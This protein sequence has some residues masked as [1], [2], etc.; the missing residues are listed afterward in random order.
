MK[1][2]NMHC[3]TSMALFLALLLA[4]AGCESKTQSIVTMQH[5]AAPK[6][7]VSKPAPAPS[8]APAP[9]PPPTPVP[10]AQTVAT[11]IPSPGAKPRSQHDLKVN[12]DDFLAHIAVLADDAMGGRGIGSRGIDQAAA[13]IAGQFALLGIAPGG[14]DGTYFQEFEVSTG[15]RLTDDHKF[16]VTG[17]ESTPERRA[18]F[19]PF[20]FSSNDAFDGEVVFVG[21]GLVNDEKNHDDYKDVDVSGKVVLMLRREPPTWAESGRTTRLATFQNKIYT[22]KEKG[23]AAVLIV[24][25]IAEDREDRLMGFRAQRGAFGLPA[26]HITQ[27]LA[28]QM[29]ASGGARNL[30]ALQSATD[31][32]QPVS[33][34]LAG[35]H[36]AG[37][38]GVEKT[39]TRERNVLGLIP[40]DGPLADEY[41]V[42]GGHYDHLGKAAT[43]GMLRQ[44][45]SDSEPRI[46]NGADD[47]ASG[48]AGVIES[49]RI[50]MS[51]RPLKRS[52][53][54]M[55][56][57]G[58]ETGL[59]G[60]KH[61]ADNPVFP[62][63]NTVAMLNMDMIGRFDEEKNTVQIFGTRAAE[64]FETLIAQ[65][66]E[67]VGMNLRGDESAIG[68]S[69]HTSFYRKEVPAMHI[70]TGLH[71]DYHRPGDDVEKV[72]ADG[73]ARVTDLVAA[74][75]YDIA[76]RDNRVTYH[77]VK[78]RAQVGSTG[79]P[80]VVMGVMPGYAG[81]D[82]TGLV[83][84]GVTDGGPA[85]KSG[86]QGGDTITRIGDAGVKNI[87]DYMG[88][89]RNRKPGDVIK[90]IVRRDDKDV[91]LDITLGGR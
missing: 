53:I 82:D 63:E 78:A 84:D 71:Q 5:R 23:A 33:T 14:D 91:V 77:E 28:E 41:V 73:G 6:T 1:R 26:F 12:P 35:V 69:D 2:L 13:Y 44:D 81:N 90:V 8:V 48:T 45:Q 62:L 67:A 87:Y 56:F 18:D 3:S 7:I 47:N 9:Q 22:A 16:D 75:A 51:R 79:R 42:I 72:N 46:H 19:T 83:V 64:E 60:S 34:S 39:V 38:A 11:S 66:V 25:R 57:S 4:L 59:L 32:S 58:E 40:G 74:M 85:E 61:Y 88:A 17:I 55:A 76:Q 49:G 21:Y 70:F 10:H 80:R 30:S 20:G 27:K 89:L 43:M 50:L 31:Q 65:H 24:N 68:P 36:L 86:M 52:I 37:R 15:G 29:L 54:L